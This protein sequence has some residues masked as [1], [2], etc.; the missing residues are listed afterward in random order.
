MRRLLIAAAATAVLAAG[1]LVIGRTAPG[2]EEQAARDADRAFIANLRKGDQRAVGA[3]LG[4]RFTFIDRAGK[5]RSRRETLADFS[6]LVAA[7]EG[8]G[9]AETR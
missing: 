9:D 1:T 6:A 2:D 3:L 4:R 7:N 8:E 5:T